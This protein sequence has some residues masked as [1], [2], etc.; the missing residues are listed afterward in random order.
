MRE[1]A[2]KVGVVIISSVFAL[3]C[4]GPS[5]KGTI[6][7][8]GYSIHLEEQI[9]QAVIK[10][11]EAP[12][13][14]TD[15]AEWRF[16]E[17]QSGWQPIVPS[18]QPKRPV[19][20]SQMKD[21]LRLTLD[22]TVKWTRSDYTYY[23]GGIWVELPDWKREDWAYIIV[24]ARAVG[25]G[26]GPVLVAMLNKMKEAD[27]KGPS[28][29]FMAS[30]ESVGVIPDGK[31]HEYVLRADWSPGEYAGREKWQNPWR[32]L[33][34]RFGSEQQATIDLLSVRVVPKEANYAAK[35]VGLSTEV[36]GISYRRAL[37]IHAPGQVSFRF[38]VPKAG[39]LDI[40]LGVIRDN[41]PVTFR[42]KSQKDGSGDTVLLEEKYTNTTEWGQR[43][44]NLSSLAGKTVDL[45]LEAES[46]RPGTV[47]LWAAPTVSG[48]RSTGRPNIILYIIDGAAADQ[49]SA[50]GYNRRTTPCLERLASEGAVFERAYSNSS[51]TK[52]SVP[53]FMTSLHSSV[54]GPYETPSD[55]IPAKAI[56][57]AERLHEAG[58]QTSVF[59]SNPHCG[60]M[61]GLERGVDVLR[62]AGVK[63]NSKSSEELQSDFWKW[64]GE[65]PG[66]PYWVHIQTTDVHQPWTQSA[67]FAGLFADPELQKTYV[68][69]LKK[70]G[71]T[72][73]TFWDR[74]QKAGVDPARFRSL[75][76]N[77]YDETMAHQ[78][79]Q[80]GRFV[81]RLKAE[82][83]WDNTLLIVTAD[84]SSGA[85]G[86]M[87]VD[88]ISLAYPDAAL[89]ASHVSHIPMIFVWPG[90]IAPGLRLTEP[91]SLIDLF[92][93]ITDLADLPGPSPTQGQSFAP[94]LLGKRGWTQRPV[95]IDEFNAW[96]DTGEWHGKIEVIDGR[97][98]ASLKVGKSP[99]EAK[100]KPE[101]L[102]PARLLLYDL[103]NDPRCVRSLHV[104]Q[105][106]LVTKYTKFLEEK[107]K[108]HRALAKKF[109]R[110]ADVSLNAEQ[111]ETLRTLGYIR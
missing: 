13:N 60:T 68:E 66:S 80:I 72:E 5:S 91:V 73:G 48:I 28:S 49:M 39:R 104:E 18:G 46:E 32:E 63:P 16:N 110:A 24:S 86:L 57:I 30:T 88:P 67:P 108:E 101:E 109:E 41:A 21:S 38:R 83:E 29:A 40:G 53:S 56:T 84:H 102:R 77:L 14:L 75:G 17:P 98:G 70:L 12:Q 65:Y 64:R 6:K 94:L 8:S 97:W 15:V 7:A 42:V 71:E 74:F 106:E 82:G 111:L 78:D 89:L 79:D 51:W 44:V 22:E 96:G 107:Y 20:V 45:T 55:R 105:P 103:W 10:G 36:R 27:V 43:S 34:I 2:V 52:I 9:S 35:P 54:L 87:S 59:V 58:Y 4:T 3:S 100:L 31:V 11:S 33:G 81:E 90:K 50:Y 1:L 76:R 85:A 25:Q 23:S 37:Y 99:W 26:R 47:A 95:I 62:E 61:S 69:W 92:P 93:T 19:T